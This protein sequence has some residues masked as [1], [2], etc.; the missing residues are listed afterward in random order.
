MAMACGNERPACTSNSSAQSKA[1]ESLDPGAM[2]GNSFLMSSP[3]NGE[4]RIDCRACIQLA[5]PFNVLI[6]PLCAT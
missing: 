3:N 2:I 1:A 6:S 4:A 5:L